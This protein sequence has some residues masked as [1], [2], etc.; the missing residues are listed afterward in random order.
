MRRLFALDNHVRTYPW[1]TTDG[2]ARFLKIEKDDAEPWAELWMGAYPTN[3]SAVI[4]WP[5]Q[6]LRTPLDTCI[7][8]EPNLFLGEGNGRELRFLFKILSAARPLSLQAHP[9][10]AQASLGFERETSAGTPVSARRFI[11]PSGKPELILAL[12]EFTMLCGFRAPEESAAL[13]SGFSSHAFPY[14]AKMAGKGEY[15]PLLRAL[16]ALAPVDRKELIE[17]AIESSV[18]R[19]PETALADDGIAEA[20]NLARL[21][22]AQYPE[23]VCVLAPFFLNVRTLSPGEATHIPTGVLHSYIGGTGLEL[24]SNSD[25]VHRA[26]LTG[27]DINVPELLSCLN[28]NPYFPATIVPARLPGQTVYTLDS[29]RLELRRI[30]VSGERVPLPAGEPSVAIG[31]RG[32]VRLFADEDSAAVKP[33][34]SLFVSGSTK[35]LRA[36]GTGVCYLAS[37]KAD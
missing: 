33:G 7:A 28:P 27:K 15:I 17:A 9:D 6:G 35:S 31:E 1:G 14:L 22:Y 30:E 26:G 5:T 32:T 21:L 23:D 34:S 37:A 29:L 16:F 18:T 2:I 8:R 19:F 10:D 13:F 25:A 36:E 3:P 12:D 24:M 11:T 4:D 20:L